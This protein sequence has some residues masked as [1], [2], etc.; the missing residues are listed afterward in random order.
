[1]KNKI[2]QML[3]S[4]LLLNALLALYSVGGIFSKL[5]SKQEFLSLQFLFFY[6]LV[7]T[8]L[9]IYAFVWQ[10]ILKKIPLTVAYANKSTVF[11]WAMI[12]GRLFFD[13]KITWYMVLGLIVVFAGIM[14][15]VSDYEN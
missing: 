5:G 11:L 14:V 8:L 13:E 9:M 1:M 3:P 12:W 7:L 10:Q 6:G 2:K 15:V 4:L